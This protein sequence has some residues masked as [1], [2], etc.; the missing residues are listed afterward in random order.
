[1][2]ATGRVLYKVVETSTVHDQSL[3]NII[4]EW[5]GQGWT[6]DSIQFVQQ[7]STRRPVMAFI[8]FTRIVLEDAAAADSEHQA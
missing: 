3:E 2:S 4:N 8:L 1:M 7:A 6:L 5:V